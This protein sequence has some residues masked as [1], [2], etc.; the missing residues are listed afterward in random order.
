MSHWTRSKVGIWLLISLLP[1][2]VLAIV[3]TGVFPDP[4]GFWNNIGGP[5]LGFYMTCAL[6]AGGIL[7]VLGRFDRSRAYRE[8]QQYAEMHGWLP[9]TKTS[10]RNRKRDNVQLAVDQA[11]KKSTYILKIDHGGET[12]VIDEFE[13]AHWALQ[14]GDW[15]WEQVLDAGTTKV[16]AEMVSEKRAEWEGTRAMAVYQPGTPTRRSQYPVQEART[17]ENAGGYTGQGQVLQ[18]SMQ[19]GGIISGDDGQRYTFEGTAWNTPGTPMA[20]QRVNFII[21]GDQAADIFAISGAAGSKSKIVAAAFAFFLGGLGGHKFYLGHPTLGIV[22]IILTFTLIGAIFWTGPVSLIEAIIYITKSDE[23][24]ER[25]Y[26]QERKA[27]F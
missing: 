24:F 9:I 1:S 12:T 3:L 18:F 7:T 21:Q 16:D 8:A 10:W 13:T 19:A 4:E 6:I 15:L 23:D 11:F 26:V 14:F 25:I 17:S 2:V 27:L 5:L 20:G 22:W